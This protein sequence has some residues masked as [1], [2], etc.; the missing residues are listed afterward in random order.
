MASVHSTI[1]A[2]T[3]AED[4]IRHCPVESIECEQPPDTT[5][6]S[7]ISSV[8]S[9]CEENQ[10]QQAE[11]SS[12]TK[13]RSIFQ[14]YWVKDGSSPSINAASPRSVIRDPYPDFSRLLLNEEEES[15]SNTYEKSLREVEYAPK[16]SSRGNSGYHSSRPLS[17]AFWG[18]GGGWFT[19][20]APSL[21]RPTFFN[22]FYATCQSE[23]A[24][25]NPKP[26]ASCLRQ[27]RHAGRGGCIPHLPSATSTSPAPSTPSSSPP[28]RFQPRVEIRRY[29]PPTETWSP[30]GWSSWF[31]YNSK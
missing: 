7:D 1:V 15:E 30:D 11:E 6:E 19:A 17:S 4:L 14:D 22:S 24:L 10:Q 28:V 18:G 13:H 23:S 25:A 8:S 31:T 2:D 21:L 20:S 27:R 5:E 26:L 9:C 16:K 3:M 12:P 29:T